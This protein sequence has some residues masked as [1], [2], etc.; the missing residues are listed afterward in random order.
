MDTLKSKCI[1]ICYKYIL[2]FCN[3]HFDFDDKKILDNS[4]MHLKFLLQNSQH[5]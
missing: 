2:L 3:N 4:L 5:S 1:F